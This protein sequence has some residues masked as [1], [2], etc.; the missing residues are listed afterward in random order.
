M[1]DVTKRCPRCSQSRPLSAFSRNRSRP[2]GLCTYCK[3]CA[4][5]PAR[6]TSGTSH[7]YH[8]LYRIWTAMLDRCENPDHHAYARY[9]G[10]G[11]TIC[12]RWHDFASFRDDIESLIGPRPAGKTLDRYPDNNGNYT[13]GNVRWATW[14]EQADNQTRRGG[15]TREQIIARREQVRWLLAEGMTCRQIAGIT[16]T[17]IRATRTDIYA[18]RGRPLPA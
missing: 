9:G 11:I 7:S 16:G 6:G 13:P 10:R 12:T 18:V 8:P 3:T 14:Q 5:L 17:G 15:L 4:K 2:D 1:S